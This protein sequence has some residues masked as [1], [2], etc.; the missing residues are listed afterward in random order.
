MAWLHKRKR[1]N[2]KTGKAETYWS[3]CWRTG[4]R[5]HTRAI[6]FLP[7]DEAKRALKV[8]EGKLA[9][10]DGEVLRS[11]GLSFSG[12]QKA[13]PDLDSYLFD[14]Y[15]PVVERDK[16]PSTASSERWSCK[17][18]TGVLGH[19][20]L[21]QIDYA[22]VD[23][24]NSERARIGRMPR[25][26]YMELRTLRYALEHACRCK[27]IDEVP[28]LPSVKMT[29]KKPVK[30]LSDEKATAMLDAARPLSRQPHKVTRGR[31]P[32]RRDRLSYLAILTGLNTGAR[33]MEIMTREWS[34]IRWD[35]GPLGTLIIASKPEIGFEVK[36]GRSRL[37]PLTPELRDEL[38]KAHAEA[39]S[40]TTGWI[41]PSPRDSTTHRKS[42]STALE[43]ACRRAG[44]ERVNHHSLRHT[45]ASRLAMAGVDRRTVMDVGGWKESRV[46]DEIYSHVTNEHVAEVMS[47]MG[48]DGSETEPPTE[49]AD[50]RDR[51]DM[52]DRTARQLRVLEGG[53]RRS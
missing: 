23:A 27:V 42:F 38:L 19:L 50:G 9:A 52:Q 24:Y 53:K 20:R 32:A 35:D 46:L 48:F 21:D 51:A 11:C 8:F 16:K 40:P 15:L 3:I 22:V 12:T 45:W 6:G 25:T 7:A 5:T 41:F 14:V 26:R 2:S 33:K 36:M 49:G 4:G 30:F 44:I 43:G 31:P 39:G 17:A 13:K 18:L 34:D 47:R 29:E 1:K 37:V 10:G 28:P